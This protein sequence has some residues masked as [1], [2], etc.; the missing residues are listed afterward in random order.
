[1]DEDLKAWRPSI[2]TIAIRLAGVNL[3]NDRRT[4]VAQ[5]MAVHSNAE[6]TGLY[7]RRNGFLDSKGP[8]TRD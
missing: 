2:G 1:M 5:C 4:G 3:T 7:D 6:T 8:T